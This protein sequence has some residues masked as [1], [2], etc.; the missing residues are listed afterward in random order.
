MENYDLELLDKCG[1]F[2][3][4]FT[5][6]VLSDKQQFR[7]QQ[8]DL[9]QS[10]IDLIAQKQQQKHERKMKK[11]EIKELKIKYKAY[12][13]YCEL[14][15]QRNEM[16]LKITE[17]KLQVLLEIARYINDFYMQNLEL[18]RQ[19][20]L[21]AKRH[22]EDIDISTSK[23]IKYQSERDDLAKI[24]DST[25][26]NYNEIMKQWTDSFN[27]LGVDNPLQI[28]NFENM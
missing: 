3:I 21:E 14:E 16:S 19:D 12:K 26:K 8:F 17:E 5:N 28:E 1:S 13:E 7:Q 23:L 18:L 27:K 2:V 11:L 15:K 9:Y 20:Y 24:I 25:Q 10:Q 22:S 4:S 6:C